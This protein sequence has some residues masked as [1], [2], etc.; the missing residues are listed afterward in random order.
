VCLLLSISPATPISTAV[1][2]IAAAVTR[3]VWAATA[4]KKPATIESAPIATAITAHSLLHPSHFLHHFP[5]ATHRLPGALFRCIVVVPAAT[6]G[7][8]GRGRR[9][10]G[11]HTIPQN[12][13]ER[14]LHGVRVC[15][16]QGHDPRRFR[17]VG[18]R[19]VNFV[20]ESLDLFE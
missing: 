2:I 15:V 17:R 10:A 8:A 1:A 18:T 5:I 6:P 13:V 9:R 3:S 14:S 12:R 16:P 11:L 19:L 4:L 7:I 20:D